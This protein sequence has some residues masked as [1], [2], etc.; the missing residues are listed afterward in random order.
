MKTP[1]TFKQSIA[2]GIVSKE[3]LGACLKSLRSRAQKYNYLYDVYDDRRHRYYSNRD[4]NQLYMDSAKN[5]EF[6]YE[7][8]IRSLL[9]HLN[10]CEIHVFET[11]DL[12]QAPVRRYYL[13][14]IIGGYDFHQP[15]YDFEV[16]YYNLKSVTIPCVSTP[17]ELP[18][19][20]D[21]IPVQ[22]A[23]KVLRGLCDG[24]LRLI[25]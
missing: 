4:R 2:K 8:Y 19:I 9:S 23:K 11:C 15:I 14:Y 12:Y 7:G 25:P 17:E 16:P 13:Y 18:S 5:V 20:K 22:F 10:P 24:S 6:K 21:L 3:M 1:K